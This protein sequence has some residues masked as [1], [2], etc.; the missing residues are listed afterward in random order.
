ML[1]LVGFVPLWV[2]FCCGKATE[3]RGAGVFE[4][5]RGV[6]KR[7]HHQTPLCSPNGAFRRRGGSGGEKPIR[8]VGW[9]LNSSIS[10]S[11]GAASGGLQKNQCPISEIKGDYTAHQSFRISVASAS[12][13]CR[14]QPRSLCLFSESAL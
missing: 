2:A 4:A 12:M 11:V 10:P 7:L 13:R 3:R 1:L 8:G 9:R 5:G 6:K 14:P